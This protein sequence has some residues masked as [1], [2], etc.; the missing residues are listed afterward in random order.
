MLRVLWNL[1]VAEVQYSI[2][3]MY[4][5]RCD[6]LEAWGLEF[7]ERIRDTPGI[8]GWDPPED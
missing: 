8:P 5:R 2:F 6:E 7:E 4:N 1:V 3:K